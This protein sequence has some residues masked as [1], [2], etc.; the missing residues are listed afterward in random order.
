MTKTSPSTHTSK[1]SKTIQTTQTTQTIHTSNPNETLRMIPSTSS[2]P[3]VSAPSADEADVCRLMS[4]HQGLVHKMTDRLL[5]TWAPED[6]AD[7]VEEWRQEMAQSAQKGLRRAV[8]K[9]DP[10]KGKAFSTY[11]M[12]WIF[13]FAHD[14]V[15]DL[16]ETYFHTSLDTPVGDDEDAATLYDCVADEAAEDPSERA[17]RAA[18]CEWAHELLDA[19]PPRERSVVARYHGLDGLPAQTFTQI[20][21]DDGVSTQCINRVY[22]RAILRMKRAALHPDLDPAA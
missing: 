8:E 5:K 2:I 9:F 18:D 13:K 20:A 1:S 7:A 11:A 22:Q 21:E 15:E 16:H 12:P 19:L 4:K 3:A 10:G 14:T 17:A 6:D